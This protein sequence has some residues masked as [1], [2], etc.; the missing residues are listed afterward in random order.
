RAGLVRLVRVAGARLVR[1]AGGR[2]VRIGVAGLAPARLVH[3]GRDRL[4]RLTAHVLTPEVVVAQPSGV[5][6]VTETPPLQEAVMP[7][8][9]A[10]VRSARMNSLMRGSS[11]SS[12]NHW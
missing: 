4:G 8:S 3:L 10:L 9:E 12:T 5:L 7:S 2:R 6:P 11:A 1:L